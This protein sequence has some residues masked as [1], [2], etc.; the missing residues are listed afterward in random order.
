MVI[1]ANETIR[2]RITGKP[3]R[4]DGAGDWTSSRLD[5]ARTDEV[6]PRLLCNFAYGNAVCTM[7]AKIKHLAFA[8]I[9]RK[10]LRNEPMERI[11]SG[12]KCHVK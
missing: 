10:M 8:Y 11:R 12:A 9:A 5:C 1:L 6:H 2:E 4:Q 3:G 7:G